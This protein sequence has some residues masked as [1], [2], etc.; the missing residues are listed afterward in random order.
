MKAKA[1]IINVGLKK[2]IDVLIFLVSVKVFFMPIYIFFWSLSL[3]VR[4]CQSCRKEILSRKPH[5][6]VL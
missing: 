4:R 1:D 5:R 3:L 6:N 2:I